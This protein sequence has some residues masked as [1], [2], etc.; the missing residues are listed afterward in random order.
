MGSPLPAR[1]LSLAHNTGCPQGQRGQVGLEIVSL[2]PSR[3]LVPDSTASGPCPGGKVGPT[4]FLMSAAPCLLLSLVPTPF[5]LSLPLCQNWE[6]PRRT[7]SSRV[8]VSPGCPL[9]AWL[10]PDLP[11]TTGWSWKNRLKLLSPSQREA[12]CFSHILSQPLAISKAVF[13]HPGGLWRQE[14]WSC[15]SLKAAGVLKLPPPP[16]SHPPKHRPQIPE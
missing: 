5:P 9:S 6:G 4:L 10:S 7:L 14:L 8:S 11:A 12:S 15:S 3:K 16:P 13:S 1:S 2:V